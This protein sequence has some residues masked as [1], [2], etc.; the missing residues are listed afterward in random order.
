M[1]RCHGNPSTARGTACT[2]GGVKRASGGFISF[3]SAEA[4][5]D[6]KR[7]WDYYVGWPAVLILTREAGEG[8][9]AKHGGGGDPKRG[10]LGLP[11]PPPSA[12]PLPRFTG[13]DRRI[14]DHPLAGRARNEVRSGSSVS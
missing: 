1:E 13:E 9:H 12:V 8:D 10:E 7:I 5:D 6:R 14:E 3:W 11:P 2:A 4:L